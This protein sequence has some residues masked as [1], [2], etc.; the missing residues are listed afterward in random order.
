MKVAFI[1]WN[2]FQYLQI[3]ALAESIPGAVFILEERRAN[4]GIFNDRFLR[5]STVPIVSCSRERLVE[6]V[7]CF[8]IFVVQTVFPEIHRLATKK[9]AMLQYGYAKEPHNYGAWR[10]L[11]DLILV[12]G[13]YAKSRCEYFAATEAIG[14]PRYDSWF[15][16]G[17]HSRAA[18]TLGKQKDPGKKTLLYL[19]TWGDLSSTEAYLEHIVALSDEYNVFVKMHHNSDLIESNRNAAQKAPGIHFF[20]ADDDIMALMSCA[21]VVVTDYSGA[22]FD[23]I[24]CDIP[25]VLI[26]TSDAALAK[27]EKID[28]F[29]A[30]LH[31]RS[32][33]GLEVESPGELRSKVVCALKGDVE[34]SQAIRKQFFTETYDSCSLARAALQNLYDGKYEKSQ[35]QIYIRDFALKH[36]ALQFKRRKLWFLRSPVRKIRSLTQRILSRNTVTNGFSELNKLQLESLAAYYRSKGNEPSSQICQSIVNQLYS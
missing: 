31:L 13:P 12:F 14:N 10:A 24:F 33:L 7:P 15:D 23:A 5:E 4:I 28:K 9:I 8:D 30:E 27:I 6:L 19:P 2:T 3:R 1:G 21:D 35:Q 16:D 18:T 29:S 11:A 36:Y 20:G 17:F 34:V 32:S 26:N 22:I 25:L